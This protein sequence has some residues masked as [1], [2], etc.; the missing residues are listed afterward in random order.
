VTTHIPKQSMTYTASTNSE[1]YIV[2]PNVSVSSFNAFGAFVDPM[3]L[4]DI[5][6]E[7]AGSLL[8]SGTSSGIYSQSTNAHFR[9]DDSGIVIGADGI[10]LLG[11]SPADVNN[12]G[13]VGGT[14]GI[15]VLSL[16]G[17]ITNTGSII[18]TT[19]GIM[20]VTSASRTTFTIDNS[21]L[22]AGNVGIDMNAQQGTVTLDAD[23]RVMATT[24]GVL[25]QGGDLKL[26]NAGL[27]TSGGGIAGYQGSAGVDNVTNT[28]KIIGNV[29]LGDGADHFT[30]TGTGNVVGAV[31][32]GL[33]DDVYL[34]SSNKMRISETNG[35]GTDTVKATASYSIANEG[36]IEN[37]TLVGKKN[38]NGF[39]NEYANT[40]TGN[41]GVNHLDGGT[42][43]DI[44]IG[45]KGDDVFVFNK[46]SGNDTINDY[47]DGHDQIKISGFDTFH[48]FK[49]LVITQNGANVFIDFGTEQATDTLM[50]EN[51]KVKEFDK[52][53]FIF[54]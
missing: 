33:G 51:A 2:D 35:N 27:I 30:Q 31:D 15:Y 32:G 16:S 42:G 26:T 23:S 46:G 13:Y 7:V 10:A 12:A 34:L 29:N 1:T 22:I 18:G 5:T 40:V 21:G 6:L 38:L 48:A 11:L 53:D 37:L 44:L 47:V 20:L 4:N 49:D 50:I 45:G 39:G 8:G 25:N 17:N 54:A 28:G 36:E 19:Y 41:K 24:Y 3:G 52:G 43:A 9:I 14:N